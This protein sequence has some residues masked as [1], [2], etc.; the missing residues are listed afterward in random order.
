MD[1]PNVNPRYSL[2]EGDPHEQRESFAD[3]VAAGLQ[4]P[5]KHLPCRFLYDEAGSHLFEEICELPEYYLTRAERQI[6]EDHADEIA[7]ALPTAAALA[8]LGSGSSA[9]TRLLIESFLRRQ[10]SLRYIP[11]DISGT[12]LDASAQQL[13]ASYAALEIRAIADEYEAGL[14]H[15]Q[16]ENGLPKLIA[17]LGSNVGNFD[18]VQAVR[19][20]RSIRA[21]MGRRDCLLL[22]IDLRKE[23]HVLERAYDDSAGITASFN[24]NLLGRI[25]RELGGHFDLDA[26]RHRADYRVVEGRVEMSLVSR[27]PQEVPIEALD[28]VVKFDAGEAIH[29]EDSYKYSVEEIGALG[30]AAD[31]R[32]VRRWLDATGHFSLN[33]LAPVA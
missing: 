29:T 9:K 33:L 6:L 3:A 14:R 20:V 4:A 24:L 10:G 21:A 15:V 2:V 28:L 11:V 1:H 25:N 31:L 26:F 27:R 19:F 7:A 32:V 30:A 22:G 18:R 5:R 16:R 8:E 12:M 17:W 13:L 23:A